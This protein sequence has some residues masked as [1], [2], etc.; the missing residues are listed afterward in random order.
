MD[1]FTQL[2]QKAVAMQK[3]VIFPESSDER[4]L[5]A[6]VEI[7]RRKIAIPLLLGNTVEIRKRSQEIGLHLDNIEIIDP[8]TADNRADCIEAFYA[9]RK[10]KGISREQA[11][12][13]M[14]NP[15]YFG[16]MYVYK[17]IVHGMVSGSLSPTSDLLRAAFQVI[18]VQPHLSKV[19]SF[20]IM[21]RERVLL[22]FAD[23]AVNPDPT[24][25]ELSSIALSTAESVQGFG[26]TPRIAFLSF[27]TH[28]SASHPDVLKVRQARQ[29]L[30]EIRPDLVAGGEMQF[31]AAYVAEVAQKKAPDSPIQ[32]DANVFIFPDLNSGNIG[33]KI[34]ERLGG[35][36]AIGPVIQGLSK[37]VNDLSRGCSVE[38]IIKMT[39]ITAN[40]H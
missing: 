3:K 14:G 11:R 25:E 26:I 16:A 7:A 17:N 18:G 5:R 20:F 1:F 30:N 6:V 9:M 24:A 34:A 23:C 37:P 33:Y 38:D 13:I 2:E 15:L 28:G 29:L 40:Q 32:G 12:E 36:E 19:S 4:I 10:A 8:L 35:F 22:F 27:S 31:D 39:I 21:K